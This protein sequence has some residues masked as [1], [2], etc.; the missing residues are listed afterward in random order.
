MKEAI[1]SLIGPVN[2][3]RIR[4]YLHPDH[5]QGWGGPFNGQQQRQAIFLSL[6][7]S[8]QPT[9]FVETGTY[10]ATTTY[11]VAKA[12]KSIPIYSV[13]YSALN[14][15][16]SYERLRGLKQ[17]HLELGDS[18]TFLRKL[19][20]SAKLPAGP[21]LFYLDAHWHDDLPLAEELELIFT[22][23]SEAIVMVDD[24]QVPWDA[25]YAF[26]DY[27]AGR[28]LTPAYIAPAVARFGLSCFY[29]SQPATEETGSRRGC[30]VMTASSTQEVRLD[31]IPGLRRHVG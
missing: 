28:A 14:L 30:V 27:G 20:A 16:F 25:G 21:T 29:P 9:A 2:Q 10:L 17:V 1:K 26:D 6:V 8:C 15:G 5:R 11:F 23:C 12:T 31:R 19:L 7:E 18:R 24:F 4:Y 3:G 22:A 13:E